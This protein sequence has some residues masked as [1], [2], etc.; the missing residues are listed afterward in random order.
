MT[1]R[2]LDL[3]PISKLQHYVGFALGA[4]EIERENAKKE[5]RERQ[6]RNFTGTG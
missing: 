4:Q 6:F 5:N 2:E 3:E 1:K